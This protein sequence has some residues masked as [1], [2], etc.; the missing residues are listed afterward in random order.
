MTVS[1]AALFTLVGVI[2]LSVITKKNC[3]IIGLVAAYF[4]GTFVVGMKASAI[5]AK[6]KWL[7]LQDKILVFL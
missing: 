3:G 2:A 4:L 6:V 5:Y 1:V 7:S